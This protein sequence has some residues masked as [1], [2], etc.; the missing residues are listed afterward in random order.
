MQ[1][2][3]STASPK[4][5]TILII[6]DAAQLS[7]ADALSTSEISF[8]AAEIKGGN[9]LVSLNQYGRFVYLCL[10]P[11][12]NAISTSEGLRRIGCTL[13]DLLQKEKAL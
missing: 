9:K 5:T 12:S 1:F 8:A 2:K 13:K 3:I 10:L 6:N 7:K 4:K 11:K